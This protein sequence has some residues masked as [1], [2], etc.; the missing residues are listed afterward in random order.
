M[1]FPEAHSNST[2]VSYCPTLVPRGHCIRASRLDL[3]FPLH[4]LGW[5]PILGGLSASHWLLSSMFFQKRSPPPS[6]LTGCA[7]EQ[8]AQKVPRALPDAPSQAV[9]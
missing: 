3:L 2:C 8:S 9:S 7:A 4:A 6:L 5:A 1:L